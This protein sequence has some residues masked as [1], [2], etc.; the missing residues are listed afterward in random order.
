MSNIEGN[1]LLYIFCLFSTGFILN[2]GDSCVQFKF[3][4]EI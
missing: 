1:K 2:L 3:L 4:L